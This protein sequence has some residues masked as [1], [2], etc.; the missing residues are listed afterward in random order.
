MIDYSISK[1]ISQKE[2]DFSSWN[3]SSTL[4]IVAAIKLTF[5]H[6]VL[7]IEIVTCR[8]HIFQRKSTSFNQD[9]R[10]HKT[11][12]KIKRDTQFSIK[13]CTRQTVHQV[14]EISV[15][16]NTADQNKYRCNVRSRVDT[17]E[18]HVRY[19]SVTITDEL[20]RRPPRTS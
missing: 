17:P 16:E 11:Q 6:T 8:K 15:K 19:T 20:T 18:P 7:I 4:L 5:R 2:I 9:S 3:F 12:I 13:F 10:A 14:T 1:F